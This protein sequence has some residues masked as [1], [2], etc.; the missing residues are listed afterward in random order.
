M[1]QEFDRQTKEF[2]ALNQR[3]TPASL[4]RQRGS[5]ETAHRIVALLQREYGYVQIEGQVTNVSD[6]SLD[7]VMAVGTFNTK[8]GT[9]VKSDH[10]LIDYQPIMVGQIGH[11][12]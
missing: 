7:T 1:G 10:A 5:A 4:Q 3:H 6:G 2:A 12:T 11:F 8:D 9:F